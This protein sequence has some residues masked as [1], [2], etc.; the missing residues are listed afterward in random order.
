MTCLILSYNHNGK[1]IA[2][3]QKNYSI[4]QIALTSIVLIAQK[5]LRNFIL[6]LFIRTL[7]QDLIRNTLPREIIELIIFSMHISAKRILRSTNKYWLQYIILDE[8][9]IYFASPKKI[10]AI[11]QHFA[12]VYSDKLIG[13]AFEKIIAAGKTEDFPIQHFA[14]LTHLTSLSFKFARG[15]PSVKKLDALV[16]HLTNLLKWP[17]KTNEFQLLNTN[18]TSLHAASGT[19]VQHKLY[20]NLRELQIS[21]YTA[22]GNPFS[23]VGN[24]SRLTSFEISL[25]RIQVEKDYANMMTQFKNL[26]SLKYYQTS[27]ST[28]P[29]IFQYLTSIEWLQIW[30]AMPQD[31]IF[32]LTRLT[33]L[34]GI[35]AAHYAL[36]TKFSAFYNLKSLEIAHHTD[37][38][39]YC[40][41][42]ALTALEN[43]R[44]SSAS[45]SKTTNG[46][47]FINSKKITRLEV[48]ST[49]EI[50]N[51]NQLSELAS[52][53]ELT[54]GENI[55][56]RIPKS[57]DGLRGLT[58][59]TK[60]F[61]LTQTPDSAHFT[62]FNSL[63]SLKEF[64]L[65][66]L[67]SDAET[68][69]SLTVSNLTN[70]E[71]LAYCCSVSNEMYN[72]VSSLTLLTH[73]AL[74]V[75]TEVFVGNLTALNN[76]SKLARLRFV[77]H[78]QSDKVWDLVTTLTNL[79]SLEVWRVPSEEVI[80]SFSVLTKLTE[81]NMRRSHQVQGIHLTKLTSLQTLNFISKPAKRLYEKSDKLVE[82]LTRLTFKEFRS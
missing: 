73:L 45:A 21:S 18:L 23:V 27:S 70:L 26:K 24:P 40:F 79:E 47:K 75:P 51:I 31:D 77:K 14:P 38:N 15:E 54:I 25:Q 72:D 35:S 66:G 46:L 62:V 57:Y 5:Y 3:K 53:R 28:L 1:Q 42:T 71:K 7:F 37:D 63:A 10:P 67:T 74:L 55:E 64:Q 61:L 76:L 29:E 12:Q 81:L 20:T 78:V 30:N 65:Y 49:A 80:E 56:Q 32:L 43:L 6:I 36:Y 2:T 60:L 13:L 59:L 4:L 48:H 44:L 11:V 41:L 33:R 19:M 50:F 82:K 17:A 58:N 68:S 52:L 34:D 69:T 9:T 39:S 8:F 16:T 22:I